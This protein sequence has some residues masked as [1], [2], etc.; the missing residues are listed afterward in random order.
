MKIFNSK[1]IEIKT[2]EEYKTLAPPKEDIQW[3]VDHSA[4]EFAKKVVNHSLEKELKEIMP[5]LEIQTAVAEKK[6][7]FD[8]FGGPRNH[9]L[10]CIGFLDNTK[11][12]LC[13]EAKATE[14][15][16]SKT[17]GKE[18]DSALK[19]RQD[20]ESTNIPERIDG[21]CYRLWNKS[22]NNDI[23]KIE[24]QLLYSTLGTTSFAK[25]KNIS[26]AIFVVYQL[27]TDLTT[28]EICQK[29]FD[30]LKEFVSLFNKTIT[31]GELC[32]IGIVDGVELSIL[33]IQKPKDNS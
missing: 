20:G 2:L 25:E 18:L 11:I 31:P 9:D 33:Y 16:G 15:F 13:F 1:N 32:H 29:H 3:A 10:A 28:R 17:V 22:I 12:V 19:K 27:E 4:M 24:Y 26:K 5:L 21:L 23:R 14:G 7:T 30:S 8:E 6:T